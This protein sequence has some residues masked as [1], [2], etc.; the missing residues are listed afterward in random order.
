[1]SGP[2]PR[3]G[4]PVRG[5]ETGRPVMA[6]FDLIGR[7]WTLRVLWE[8][9][10]TAEP[11]TFR[12]LQERCADMSSSVL[13]TRLR[14][15]RDAQLVDVAP[16]GY[17]LTDLGESLLRSLQPVSEWATVWAAALRSPGTAGRRRPRAS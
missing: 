15:L 8:L 16:K 7:R 12:E 3:P 9:S 14:E 1:M 17:R 10:Q 6:L 5:S 13:S 2:A 11:P 4:A